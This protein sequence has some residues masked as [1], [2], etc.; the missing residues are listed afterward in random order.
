MFHYLP[1]LTLLKCGFLLITVSKIISL[2]LA[3][4]LA[5]SFKVKYNLTL[6]FTTFFIHAVLIVSPPS[7][8]LRI[9]LDSSFSLTPSLTRFHYQPMSKINTFYFLSLWN[10]VI[11]LRKAQKIGKRNFKYYDKLVENKT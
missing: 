4:H 3:N 6:L 2:R 7:Q 8:S 10:E 9:V 11:V 5:I 1:I